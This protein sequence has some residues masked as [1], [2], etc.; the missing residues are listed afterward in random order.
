MPV[1]NREETVP[2][3]PTYRNALTLGAML[4]EYRL[5]SVLGA[6]G[7]GMTYLAWDLN[8]E[9][10]VAIKEYL[11]GELAIRALDGSIVPVNTESEY[12]Y[13]WGL[14]RFILEART[15]AKFSHPNIVRVNRFFEA[16]GTSY[17]VM[18]YEAGESLY[19]HLKRN[20]RPA[21]HWLKQILMPILDG[22]QAV[23]AA[24][25]LHRDIK[26]SNVFI[27][28][29]GTPVLLD[30]GSARLATGGASKNLTAI[31]SPGYA[32]LEQYAADGN[33]GP[34]SD[35]YA[36]SGVLY[37]A[38][39]GENPPDAVKR[40]RDDGVPAS[41][42]AVRVHYDE[43]FLRAIEWGLAIEERVRP[44]GVA[45]WREWLSATPAVTAMNSGGVAG[46]E[47]PTTAPT[48]R[49]PSVPTVPVPRA[50][51]APSSR[52]QTSRLLTRTRW[53][54][55]RRGAFLLVLLVAGVVYFKQRAIEK[56]LREAAIEQ[57]A[58]ELPPELE[59]RLTQRF[60]SAD[61]DRSGA[62]SREELARRLPAYAGRF[63][64]IDGNGD[65]MVSMS[66][67]TAFMQKEGLSD[68]LR[69]SERKPVAAAPVAPAPDPAPNAAAP[70]PD[71]AP[72]PRSVTI[73]LPATAP[74][75]VGA[76][77]SVP[78]AVM[79]EFIG[80][81]RDGNGFLAPDEVRGRFPYIERNFAQ[82]DRDGDGRI[83]PAEL[84]HLR[85]QQKLLKVRP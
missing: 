61:A 43:R 15:L 67:L 14:E 78:P 84:A 22:L 37:R 76:A 36:L 33:Q 77:S 9:K 24:G 4:L 16:N 81:D 53:K 29:N 38:V 73:T 57:R 71:S 23:H 40:M 31:I 66:E 70:A 79:Q 75:P 55:F 65:G 64:E 27:R 72:K 30:F 74:A 34:W 35:I 58:G 10:H 6:G 63:A 17:M 59:R 39:T 50:D 49:N 2:D 20:P 46:G 45:E 32:P 26:P 7:F 13:K 11:P 60:E 28:G 56:A 42:A 1:A 21:E 8:L 62:I 47:P 3:T 12:D 18:D 54:W 69:D 5:D 19:Q 68:E 52:P 82:V 83:S 51:A 41:L 85:T 25:F 44:K 80:A 48:L